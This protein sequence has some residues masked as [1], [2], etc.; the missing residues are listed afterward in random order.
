MKAIIATA[1]G[2]PDILQLQDIPKPTPKDN[3]VLIKV[4]AAAV[5]A[6][7]TMMRV[8]I[9]AI[10]RLFLGLT[11]P[12]HP[13]PGTGLS[14]VIEATGKDVTEFNIGD[15]VFGE[16]IATFGTY[17]QYC[18]IEPKVIAHKPSAL[19]HAEA[20]PICDGPVTS[21]NFLKNLGAI[22]PG[23]NV[24][25]NGAAGSLG[26]AAI[27]IAKH[28][29]ASVTGVCSTGNVAFVQS[30]GADV[31]ID[32]TQEDFTQYTNAYDIIYDTVGKSSFS[33]C[34]NTLT[35][36]GCYL[37]PVLGLPLLFQML[38]TAKIG[39]KKA[40]FSATGALPTQEVLAL[41]KEVI[42][43]IDAGNL[44]SIIDKHYPLDQATD[45]HRHVETGHKKANIV[46]DLIN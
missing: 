15:E 6:A 41:L 4:H 17:A 8:P 32:Y 38:C 43:I 25:I 11:K 30:L 7:D 26:T 23:D 12:K 21:L 20:A 9:P 33:K 3:E 13:I 46:L 34:K 14:G 16:S 2:T 29:G 27:Q 40:K 1:Y 10:G 28:F 36:N 37:S 5:T 45:A 22:K 35:Q 42:E 24:L 19:T 44:K 31:V 39:S 18:C